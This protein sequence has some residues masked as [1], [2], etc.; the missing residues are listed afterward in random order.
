MDS[1]GGLLVKLGDRGVKETKHFT[2]FCRCPGD[3]SKVLAAF[4][5]IY[6]GKCSRN[7]GPDGRKTLWWTG[8]LVVIGT[9]TIA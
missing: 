6:D 5:E 8:R 9:V 4:R 7:V 1:S 2:S 3:G